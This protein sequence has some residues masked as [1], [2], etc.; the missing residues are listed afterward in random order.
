LPVSRRSLVSWASKKQN[1]IT[2]STARAEY[3]YTGQCCAQLLWMRQTLKDFDYN[4]SK[5]SLLCDN[6]SAIRMADNP[7]DHDHTKHIDIWYHFLR[8]HSQR[9]DIVIDL[10]STHKQFTDISTKPLDKRRFCDLSNEVNI[11]DSRNMD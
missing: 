6:E 5:V 2:L 8:D 3:I 4:L 1:S 11:L 7:I 9:G 10:V